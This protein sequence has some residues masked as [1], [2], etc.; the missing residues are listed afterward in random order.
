MKWIYNWKSL[1]I[2]ILVA[3]SALVII[4]PVFGCHD[5]HKPTHCHTVWQL[6]Y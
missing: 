1:V 6:F 3:V 2:V 4:L 5:D